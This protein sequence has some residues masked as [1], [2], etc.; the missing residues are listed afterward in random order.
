M[1][2]EFVDSTMLVI[3]LLSE[4]PETKEFHSL[5][6]VRTTANSL[7]RMSHSNNKQDKNTN[8]IISRQDYHLTQPCPRWY[9][10]RG[11]AWGRREEI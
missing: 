3:L 7:W 10:T 4:R 5:D 1:V 8:T 6:H 2:S 11:R 9:S